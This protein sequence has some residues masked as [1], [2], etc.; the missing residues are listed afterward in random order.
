MPSL[1]GGGSLLLL[2]AIV[3]REDTTVNDG[4]ATNRII[5]QRILWHINN[6]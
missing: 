4:K 2:L 6:C 1:G 3:D 5:T